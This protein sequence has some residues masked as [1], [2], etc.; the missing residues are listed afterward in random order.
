MT[1][2]K[3]DLQLYRGDSYAWRFR[4]WTDTAQTVPANLLGATAMAQI[5]DKSAGDKI[6]DLICTI[7]QPNL[8][9]V[10]MTPAKYSTCPPSGVWDLQIT[11]S[12][13]QVHTP[14]AGTVTVTPDVTASQPMALMVDSLRA[15]RYG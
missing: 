6:V 4:I 5:R 2:G 10:S 1:P 3:F 13:G 8:I 7:T 9:D 15:A 14:I 12:D 11:Y